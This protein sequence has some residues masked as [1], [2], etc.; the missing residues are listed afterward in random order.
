MYVASTILRRNLTSRAST[1]AAARSALLA[2]AGAERQSRPSPQGEPRAANV[3]GV[4]DSHFAAPKARDARLVNHDPSH[5]P[6]DPTAAGQPH[7]LT[8]NFGLEEARV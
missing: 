7:P 3:N 2:T 5:H 4:G 6:Q 1:H 8:G